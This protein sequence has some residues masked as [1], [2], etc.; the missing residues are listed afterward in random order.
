MTILAKASPSLALI[1]YWGKIPGA[2]NIPAT[3]SLA[4]TLDGLSTATRARLLPPGSATDEVII[5]GEEQPLEAYIHVLDRIRQGAGRDDRVRMESTNTFPTSA[6]LASSSSGFA[7]LTLAVSRLLGA[8]LSTAELSS[9]ARSGSGSASRALLCGFT[10][11]E[12]GSTTASAFLPATHWPE[13]RIVVAVVDTGPKSIGSRPAM[14]RSRTTSPFYSA[15]VERSDEL[16]AAGKDAVAARDIRRL[17]EAMQQS[18]LSM[19]STMF[20]SSPPVFYWQPTSVALIRFCAELRDRGIPAWETMDAGPQVKI[21]TTRDH[22]QTIT[23]ELA[24]RH[25]ELRLLVCRPG[26]DPEVSVEMESE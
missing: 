14:E 16:F 11:W 9:I 5:N 15:W 10:V 18:Y 23:T 24:G 4:V 22:A 21:V 13:L 7:A 2:T 20:T 1:K 12:R 17:G 8:D 25:P 3:S 6:G 19:F 26:G